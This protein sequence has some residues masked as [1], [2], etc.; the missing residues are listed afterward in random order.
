MR[1]K[2]NGK[3]KNNSIGKDKLTPKERL[4]VLEYVK[5]FN[6]TQ[7]FKKVYGA[8][9]DDVA[10]VLGYKMLR[11][12]KIRSAVDEIL[13]E[14]LGALKLE[15]QEVVIELMKIAFVD[16]RPLFREDGTFKDINELNIF[17]QA[18]IASV[19]SVELFTGSGKNKERIG[20]ITKVKFHSRLKALGHLLKH[21]ACSRNG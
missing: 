19:K 20:K 6:A 9:T 8:S 3:S 16:I 12:V 4:F 11:K 14:R 5:H 1:R 21:L 18:C 17:Q 13:I 15:G 10:G 2:N 7:S